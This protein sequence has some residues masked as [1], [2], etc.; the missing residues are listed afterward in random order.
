MTVKSKYFQTAGLLICLLATSIFSY[1]Q[2]KDFYGFSK[3][4]KGLES[5]NKNT[6]ISPTKFEAD[7]NGGTF[8][9]RMPNTSGTCYGDYEFTWKFTEDISK[10]ETG[11]EYPVTVKG[12]RIG[13][14][15]EKN[16]AK[17]YLKSG[18]ASSS[19]LTKAG[20]KS[21]PATSI[22]MIWNTTYIVDAF[23]VG[24]KNMLN[25]KVA[26]NGNPYAEFS[27]F[28]LKF[29]F[30]SFPY[31]STSKYCT[32][33]V[34]YVYQKNKAITKSPAGA[35]NCPVLYGLGVNIGIMEYGSLENAKSYFIAGFVDHALDHMKASGCIPASEIAYLEDLKI[36][37]LKK[38]TTKEFASEISLYRQRL[39]T[40]IEEGC[41]CVK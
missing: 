25:A 15:C 7:L 34:L 36:R 22:K 27:S 10:L 4:L 23:P 21:D 28:G 30:S 6:N 18:N 40:I 24:D 33:D 13:G 8:Q 20:I 39:T 9:I 11:K 35:V 17:T 37:M 12:R 41:G 19:L 32:F 2:Q 26:V 3:I 16:T 1:A 14:D 29:Y 38:E 5:S 31:S